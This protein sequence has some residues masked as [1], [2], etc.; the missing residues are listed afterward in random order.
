MF[1]ALSGFTVIA[2][3]APW[4]LAAWGPSDVAHGARLAPIGDGL[5]VLPGVFSGLKGAGTAVSTIL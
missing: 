5:R 1:Y 2:L 3:L 4:S